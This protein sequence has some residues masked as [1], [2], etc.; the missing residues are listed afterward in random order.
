LVIRDAIIGEL[1]F[2]ATSTRTVRAGNQ[3]VTFSA[4]DDILLLQQNPTYKD[5]IDVEVRLNV[6]YP[7][8]YINLKLIV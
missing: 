8:N 2:R 3:L 4:E 7:L 6:P 1:T 5:R